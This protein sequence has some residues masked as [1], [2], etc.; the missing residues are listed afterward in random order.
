M[1]DIT[2]SR[3]T[4]ADL[5]GLQKVGKQTFIETFAAHNT[6]EDMAA[7]LENGFAHDKL[8]AE[9]NNP[10]SEFYFAH[11]AGEIIGY[12]KINTGS[13]QTELRDPNALEI[14]R[15]YVLQQYQ[16]K[17]V[18]QFLYEWALQIARDRNFDYV[19]LGVW[20]HN[21]KAQHFYNKNGFVP[22][23]KHVFKLGSDDQTDIMM[24]KILK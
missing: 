17:K 21:T 6:D 20:E 15:I 2:L 11:L 22:F 19:W 24:K 4:P 10:E 16:G 5:E 7:Y 3:I 12:L 8:L 1:E 14:E 23:D 18:G 9:I 13:A